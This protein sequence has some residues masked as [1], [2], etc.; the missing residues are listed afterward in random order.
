MIDVDSFDITPLIEG[1][2]HISPLALREG[3]ALFVERHCAD[4]DYVPTQ[5]G[6]LRAVHVRTGETH[7]FG[8]DVYSARFL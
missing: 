2:G 5:P 8:E 3:W 7:T 6:T 1:D 4:N